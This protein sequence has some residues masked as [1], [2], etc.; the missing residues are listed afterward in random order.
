M[1]SRQGLDGGWHDLLECYHDH[2]LLPQHLWH[3][4]QGTVLHKWTQETKAPGRQLLAAF[5][6]PS[7]PAAGILTRCNLDEVWVTGGMTHK[8]VTMITTFRS[9]QGPWIR[10]LCS[11][12]GRRIV[13]APGRLSL[14]VIWAPS[15]L[16]ERT[17]A[18]LNLGNEW[19]TVGTTY[20]GATT[21]T[22][23]RRSKHG[24]WTSKLCPTSGLRIPR[25]QE[26][27]NSP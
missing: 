16:A 8:G 23:F 18:R 19:M 25:L 20:E 13:K 2:R 24:P 14:V 27:C 11:T 5:W 26:G 22:T 12:S 3:L 7:L 21:T 10:K 4:D 15:P 1:Q 17:L 6:T 9:N